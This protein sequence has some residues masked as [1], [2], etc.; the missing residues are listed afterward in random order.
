[1]ELKGSSLL[2][3]GGKISFQTFLFELLILKLTQGS[4]FF[5]LIKSP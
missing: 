3:L 5:E 4:T 2:G 1:M